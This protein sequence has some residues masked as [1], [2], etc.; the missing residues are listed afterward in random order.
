MSMPGPREV[1]QTAT[2][3]PPSPASACA[4]SRYLQEIENIPVLTPDEERE[5]AT[6]ARSGETKAQEELVRRN[7]RFVVSVARQYARHG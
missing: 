7:L 6:R 5:I 1:R 2:R 3:I 4:L